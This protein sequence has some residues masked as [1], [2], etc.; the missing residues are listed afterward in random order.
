MPES[1]FLIH[2]LYNSPHAVLHY[3]YIPIANY[4]S[5]LIIKWQSKSNYAFS[6]IP[7]AIPIISIHQKKIFEMVNFAINCPVSYIPICIALH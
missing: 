2:S 7:K 5:I 3:K 6:V 1:L 4:K